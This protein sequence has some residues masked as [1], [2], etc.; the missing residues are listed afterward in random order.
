MVAVIDSTEQIAIAL[1]PANMAVA[2][3]GR[4]LFDYGNSVA[5]SSGHAPPAN[6]RRSSVLDFLK[7]TAKIRHIGEADKLADLRYRSVR[8]NKQPLSLLYTDHLN[9]L[10]KRFAGYLFENPAKVVRA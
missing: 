3:A 2:Y 6:V 4:L 8:M 1:H 7:Y 10:N 9:I 5:A